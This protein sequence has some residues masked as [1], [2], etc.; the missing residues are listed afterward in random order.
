[1]IGDLMGVGGNPQ[2]GLKC[3]WGHTVPQ[4]VHQ[5]RHSRGQLLDKEHHHAGPRLCMMISVE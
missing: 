1:M 4:C 5:G 2:P 3:V